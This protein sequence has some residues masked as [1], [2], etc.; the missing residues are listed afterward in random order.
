MAAKKRC[1]HP[2]AIL[3]PLAKSQ[4]QKNRLSAV[5]DILILLCFT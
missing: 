1:C 2:A 3:L 5:N 4:A